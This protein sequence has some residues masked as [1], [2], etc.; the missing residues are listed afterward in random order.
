[1]LTRCRSWVDDTMRIEGRGGGH[2]CA[3]RLRTG[4]RSREG[5]G[6]NEAGRQAQKLGPVVLAANVGALNYRVGVRGD[7]F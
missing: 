2:Y 1:M 7:R 4:A 5:V 3:A 6:R